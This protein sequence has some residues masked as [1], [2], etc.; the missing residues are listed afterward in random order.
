MQEYSIIESIKNG[1]EEALTQ[2]Y[3]RYRTEFIAWMNKAYGCSSEQAR[4]IY[5]QAIII[6]YEN[7]TTGKLTELKSSEKTY[8]FAIGKNKFLEESKAA[9]RF[10]DET[11]DVLQGLTYEKEE[12]KEEEEKVLVVVEECLGK[13]GDPCKTLLELYYYHKKSM[14]EICELLQ[15]KNPATAKNLKYKCMN[16]LRKIIEQES[17]KLTF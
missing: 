7:I 15:Y 8:L 1:E 4:E 12:Y 13:L 14:A 6:F 11:E 5:Q 16:R 3:I 2:L 9:Q 17:P 10:T